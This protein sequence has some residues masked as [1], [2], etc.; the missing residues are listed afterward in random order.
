MNSYDDPYDRSAEEPDDATM[1]RETFRHSCGHDAEYE[2]PV[3]LETGPVNTDEPCWRCQAQRFPD[4]FSDDPTIAAA[5]EQ[6]L[7]ADD[8]DEIH[9]EWMCDFY[10]W[11]RHLPANAHNSAWD[12]HIG[13]PAPSRPVAEEREEPLPSIW[14]MPEGS[15]P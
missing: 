9:H 7:S 2:T 14:S 13:L 3:G 12:P 11:P 1:I 4:P 5:G 10:G 6:G 8:V 15:T